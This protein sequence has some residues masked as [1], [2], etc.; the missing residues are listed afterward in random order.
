MTKPDMKL[1]Y[2]LLAFAER[3]M[4]ILLKQFCPTG[5]FIPSV[6]AIEPKKAQLALEIPP[7]AENWMKLR[8]LSRAKGE[9]AGAGVK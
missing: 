1:K 6:A 5:I 2:N 8:K 3:K 9:L 7:A 4:Q